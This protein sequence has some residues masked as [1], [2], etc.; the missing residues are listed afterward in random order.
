MRTLIMRHSNKAVQDSGAWQLPPKSEEMVPIN[1]SRTEWQSYK[2]CYDS[3]KD[4]FAMFE[5]AG[6]AGSNMNFIAI[7]ALLQPLRRICSGGKHK[8]SSLTVAL[9]DL[10]AQ[11][12]AAP[13]GPSTGVPSF[14]SA[15]DSECCVCFEPFENPV[16]TNVCFSPHRH[17]SAACASK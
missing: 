12:A 11:Q 8:L 17:P 15:D 6:P 2:T 1:L 7:M 16:R 13:A 3:V 10:H 5:Q 9:P 4:A 14:P